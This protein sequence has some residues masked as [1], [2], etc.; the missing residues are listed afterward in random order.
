MDWG[1]VGGRADE[2]CRGYGGAAT[3]AVDTATCRRTPPP[4]TEVLCIRA[5][6]TSGEGS[7]PCM[8]AGNDAYYSAAVGSPNWRWIHRIP[9]IVVSCGR[10]ASLLRRF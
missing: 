3:E 1:N 8:Y 2:R 6:R 10:L 7:A 5:W 9:A 4:R